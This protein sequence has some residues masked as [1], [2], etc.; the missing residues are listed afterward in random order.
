M[1]FKVP[2]IT[3]RTLLGRASAAVA[4]AAAGPALAQG[5]GPFQLAPLPYPVNALEP[6]I[7]ARTMEFHHDRHHAA[8]VGALNA[9]V[10]DYP[11][12]GA[13][14]LEQLLFKLG[15]LPEAIRNAVRNNAGSHA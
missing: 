7:D 2:Q 9:A 3:R 1:R 8:A 13:M 10:K 4:I 11:E 6:H 12:V 5:A 15:E 14:R